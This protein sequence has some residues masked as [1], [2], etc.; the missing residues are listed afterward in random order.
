MSDESSRRPPSEPTSAL[1]PLSAL[2]TRWTDDEGN[3]A[4][5]PSAIS[6]RWERLRRGLEHGTSPRP[7][8]RRVWL[9]LGVAGAMAVGVALVWQRAQPPRVTFAVDG[10]T[11]GGDGYVSGVGSAPAA[12]RFSEGTKVDLGPGSRAFVVSTDRRGAR[13]RLEEGR[14]HVAVVHR[15]RARWTVEAGPF[16]V[17]VTGTMFDVHWS[18]GD[19]LF[20]VHLIAGSVRVRGPLTGEGV[21]LRAGERF[22]ARPNQRVMQVERATEET[23]EAA[24]APAATSPA[25]ARAAPAPV[26]VSPPSEP[27]A[28]LLPASPASPPSASSAGAGAAAPLRASRARVVASAT[29]GL[30]GNLG[31]TWR[32]RVASGDFRSVLDEAEEQGTAQCLRSLPEDRLASLADAARYAGRSALA[33]DVLLA[34]RSRFAGSSLARRAAFLL[35]RLAEESGETPRAALDWYETYLAEAPQGSYA[36]EALGRKMLVM[37]A[38]GE[39][40]AAAAVAR[41]YLDRFPSGAYAGSARAITDGAPP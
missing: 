33:R 3:R 20:E 2:A 13:L 19:D 40:A 23:T 7:R 27:P 8:G 18:G 16:T 30:G 11:L 37:R 4:G 39:T 6:D 28:P 26:Q 32:Q 36:G 9:T 38:N 5:D 12:L 41:E 29:P 22:Q 31:A 24:Q 21:T 14:A 25:A 10:A 35:G 17:Q 34:Q 1:R 15:P